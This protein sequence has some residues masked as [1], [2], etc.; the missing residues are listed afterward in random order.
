MPSLSLYSAALLLLAGVQ[1]YRTRQG[2]D[3]TPPASGGGT[4]TPT[5][6]PGWYD[7]EW[8]WQGADAEHG[9][10][11]TASTEDDM[12][13]PRGIRNNNPGNIE[14][15]GT[16]WQGLADPPT[17]GRYCRFVEPVYGIRAIARVLETYASSY[18]LNTVRGIIDR[19]AP[20]FEND[21]SSYVEHVA[22]FANVGPD[23]LID[24][25]RWNVS[26]ALVRA[27]ITHENGEQPYA[28]TLIER[29]VD[30]A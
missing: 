17:D 25:T 13:I 1:A 4:T 7:A 30:M 2:S 29:G 8:Y 26:Q 6:S 20:P 5:P 23:D 14:Y 16:A 19:W 18:G 22:G 11:S 9:A 21:T 12:S 27:I 28:Q 24:V 15:N 3:T 10:G